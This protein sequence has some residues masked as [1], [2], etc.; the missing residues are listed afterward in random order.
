MHGVEL[1][2]GIAVKLIPHPSEVDLQ[3][4]CSDW[5]PHEPGV[6]DWAVGNGKYDTVIEIG[7]NVGVFTLFFTRQY[8]HARIYAFEPSGMAYRRLLANLAA[9]E[10]ERA[11]TFNCAVSNSTEFMD[12]FEPYRALDQW[13]YHSDAAFAAQFSDKIATRRVLAIDAQSLAPL[14]SGRTLIQTRRRGSGASCSGSAGRAASRTPS[15]PVD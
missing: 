1:A 12:F 8:P 7:A 2:R 15:R 10:E 13:I 14:I 5:L 4:S 3:R 9:N 6:F 11:T